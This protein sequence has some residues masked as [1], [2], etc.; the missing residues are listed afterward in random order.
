MRSAG[1]LLVAFLVLAVAGCRDYLAKTDQ[2]VVAECH[3]VKLY[4][5]DL[6]GLVPEGTS[7]MDSL[8]RVNAFVDSWIRR[9]LLLHQAENNLSGEQ[10]DFTKQ[11]QD[12]RNSL[13]IYAYETLLIEQDL[14]TVVD[15]EEIE[16][17]YEANK[18]NFV[19][20]STMVKAAYVVIAD[21]N[22]HRK[23]FQQ[24]MGNPD[25]L[26]LVPLDALAERYA[27]ASYL[28]VDTWVRLDD[29]LEE[30]PL[31][32]Y[33]TESF[34]KKNRFVVFDKDGLA[35]M[36]RFEDYL[37]KETVSPL[38]IERDNIRDIILLMREKEL[39][40]RMREELY[41]KALEEHVFE[42]Y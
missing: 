33:N 40:S 9:Q 26:K 36:V 35:Y 5:E 15:E 20:R 1:L 18:S 8:T 14:D 4:A 7:R 21:D 34:L 3:G 25:T 42:I 24:L 16:A 37:M 30:V 39:L 23:D 28:D 10:L 19:L 12:Y 13:V 17:Y 2:E 31:E 11:L 22:K 32:I 38:E 27:L 6:A 41:E 29:L